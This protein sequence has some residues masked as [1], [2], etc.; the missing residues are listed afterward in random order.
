[1]VLESCMCASGLSVVVGPLTSEMGDTGSFCTIFCS[2]AIGLTGW[3]CRVLEVSAPSLYENRVLVLSTPALVFPSW[4]IG[5]SVHFLAF[6]LPFDLGSGAECSSTRGVS[7]AICTGEMVLSVDA[8]QG[9][10]ESM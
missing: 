7:G 4:K 1:M 3:S 5:G 8:P 2:R 10:V 6:P 9:D